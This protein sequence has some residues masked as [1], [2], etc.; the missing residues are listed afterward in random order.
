[1]RGRRILSILLIMTMIFSVVGNDISAVYAADVSEKVEVTT[2]ATTEDTNIVEPTVS[3]DLT[4][5][6]DSE[7]LLSITG[8]GDY[9]YDIDPDWAAN[10]N[11]IKTA[12]VDVTGITTTARMFAN[13][14]SLTSVDLTNLDTSKVTNMTGMFY[15]CMNLTSIDMSGLDTSKLDLNG[16]QQIFNESQ[17]LKEIKLPASS[18]MKLIELPIHAVDE[19]YNPV[20][21][22]D[23]K[24]N[25]Y[26]GTQIDA[27]SDEAITLTR[28]LVDIEN[29]R[30]PK[31]CG[32]LSWYIDEAGCLY[33]TGKGDY[34]GTRYG[35]PDWN[36]YS[37]WIKS[38]TVNVTNITSIRSM[39]MG[40]SL[41][42]YI[43]N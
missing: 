36:I 7:G 30:N 42:I 15:G 32:D 38:A 21:W 26:Y 29:A 16:A 12:V 4:W 22:K 23:N 6:I 11:D 9:S 41:H 39:F 37:K 28:T 18:T 24:G 10:A 33:I 35:Y 40:C 3:G 20:Y 17:R 8:E 14:Y 31:K 34:V 1:M 13:C 5:S 2:E 43:Y 27:D 25:D 19:G